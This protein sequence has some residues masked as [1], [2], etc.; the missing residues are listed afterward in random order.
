MV[1]VA[2]KNFFRETVLVSALLFGGVIRPSLI[3][4]VYVLLA[5]I[6]PLLAPINKHYPSVS[7][8]IKV[9]LILTTIVSIG[10]T[11]AQCVYQC[12]E[13]INTPNIEDYT[14]DCANS[15][16]HFWMRQIGFVR[17]KGG[18][19]LDT[20]RVIAPE[21]LSS[22]SS[23]IT[24][25]I[26]LILS[27]QNDN[28][29]YQHIGNMDSSGANISQVHPVTGS[30]RAT[31]QQ[32]QQEQSGVSKSL[33]FVN[34]LVVALKR[35]GDVAIILFIGLVGIIQPSILNSMYFIS[36]L[37]VVT[38]W[39]SYTPFHRRCNNSI[40]RVLILYSAVHFILIYIYQIPFIQHAI[41]S[42]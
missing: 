11:I 23:L 26:C 25:I 28:L 31:V 36:F 13:V 22:L 9:Y 30:P 35:L 8:P 12:Y 15:T 42:D 6:G 34:A 3:S 2:V 29:Q 37:F 38:W 24:A 4:L 16:L 1:S 32:Q 10:F 21:I 39:S 19:G 7:I 18:V 5:L 40:K 14:R 27:H 33:K 20:I 17:V 41:P